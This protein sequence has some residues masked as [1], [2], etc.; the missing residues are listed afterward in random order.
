[1]NLQTWCF[2]A[3]FRSISPPPFLNFESNELYSICAKMCSHLFLRSFEGGVDQ[4]SAP[5]HAR[6]WTKNRLS[7]LSLNCAAFFTFCV[8][9]LF[10]H[11]KCGAT[12]PI[13]DFGFKVS[14]VDHTTCA[15]LCRN[16][17]VL[18]LTRS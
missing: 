10:P 5:F 14:Y 15:D 18:H 16:I 3:A 8:T 9:L 12:L 2:F 7:G 4:T 11:L 13:E 1:M 6:F 17:Y